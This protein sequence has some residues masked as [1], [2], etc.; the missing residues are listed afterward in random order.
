MT[1]TR[2]AVITAAAGNRLAHH[3]FLEL[4]RL[5]KRARKSGPT[6]DSLLTLACIGKF[7]YLLRPVGPA[8]MSQSASPGNRSH[9]P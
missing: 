8:L 9:D 4:F 6:Q 2:G 3:L 5:K 1:T 7:S